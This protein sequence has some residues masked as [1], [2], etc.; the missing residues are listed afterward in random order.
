MVAKNQKLNQKN[1]VTSNENKPKKI[2]SKNNQKIE[3]VIQVLENKTKTKAKTRTK[4]QKSK[5][6]TKDAIDKVLI[7]VMV[8]QLL[9][10][11]YYFLG[12]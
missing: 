1:K 10:L 8:A 12:Y 4:A 5:I 6:N 3:S 2:K 11:V 9:F 7:F